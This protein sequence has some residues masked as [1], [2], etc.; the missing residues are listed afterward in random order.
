VKNTGTQ[1]SGSI[2][3]IAALSVAVLFVAVGATLG[4]KDGVD[5][6]TA[7]IPTNLSLS[8]RP[9]IEETDSDN[10]GL[11]DWQEALLGTDPNNP[12]SDGN[13]ISDALEP[14]VSIATVLNEESGSAQTLADT[15]G[16]SLVGEYLYLKETDTYTPTAGERL[17]NNLAQKISFN[18]EFSPFIK[19]DMVIVNN[20]SKE[21]VESHR[22]ALQKALDPF[23]DLTGA[24][25]AI[26]AQFVAIGDRTALIELSK[27]AL[28]YERAAK[29]ILKIPAPV[30]VAETHLEVANALSFF[31]VVLN[32]MVAKAD[33]PIASLALLRTYNQSEQ[34]VQTTFNVL[35]V[36]YRSRLFEEQNIL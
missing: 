15:I 9:Y 25:V 18:T 8:E 32:N 4:S 23:L 24:E 14:K 13:G 20:T 26:Y 22:K 34:Y 36:Y 11:P 16:N 29:E 10:D 1:F 7:V 27:R 3:I 6:A 28:V 19:D 33:D 17:G 12:D 30:D 35:S 2:R 21:A 31:S 5:R